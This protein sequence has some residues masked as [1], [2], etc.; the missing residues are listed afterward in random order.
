VINYFHLVVRLPHTLGKAACRSLVAAVVT[1][2]GSSKLAVTV[3]AAN[4][5]VLPVSASTPKIHAARN[6]GR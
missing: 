3:D 1:L 2:T 5:L 6:V 4:G